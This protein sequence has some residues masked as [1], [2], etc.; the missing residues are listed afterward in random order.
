M[1]VL[2]DTDGVDLIARHGSAAMPSADPIRPCLAVALHVGFDK[3]A[4]G[5]DLQ[6]PPS[7]RRRHSFGGPFGI[8]PA[9]R[10]CGD[11][12]V[13][14]QR[15]HGLLALALAS[16]ARRSPSAAASRRRACSP[17]HVASASRSSPTSQDD[18]LPPRPATVGDDRDHGLRLGFGTEA[19]P[20]DRQRFTDRFGCPLIQSYGFSEG[21]CQIARTPDTPPAALGVPAD[22][23]LDVAVVDPATGKECQRARFDDSGRLL[24]AGDATGEIVSRNGLPSFEGYYNNPEAVAERLRDGWYWTGDLAFRDEAGFFYFAGRSADRIR[25]DSENFAA[26]PIENILARYPAFSMVAVYPVPDPQTGDQVMAAVELHPDMKFD[27]VAFGDWLVAQPTSA[28]SGHH[29]SCA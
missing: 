28:R 17:T 13:P 16:G 29:D 12:D 19:S 8:T 24:N 6:Q 9:S 25:V 11:A 14:R 23:S 15:P 4:K 3:R 21:H 20:P 26:A 10:V 5:R 18:R 2:D 7:R 27:P 22:P 1:I